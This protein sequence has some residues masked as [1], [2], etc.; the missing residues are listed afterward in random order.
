MP[1]RLFRW[2]D[3][4]REPRGRATSAATNAASRCGS[5]SS[6]TVARPCAAIV[7]RIV[8]DAA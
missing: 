2:V 6:M 1:S 4:E 7:S 8:A 3:I 5:R